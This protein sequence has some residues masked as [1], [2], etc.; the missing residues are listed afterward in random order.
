MSKKHIL[1]LGFLMML[2]FPATLSA[3][4]TLQ[5]NRTLLVNSLQT[6]PAGKVWKVE[7]VLTSA[8]LNINT[9]SSSHQVQTSA[10]VVNGSTI[11]VSS[12]WG[13]NQAIGSLNLT[14]LPIW[15]PAGTT[16]NVSTNVNSISVIEF[17]E[18][19]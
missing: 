2:A 4:N 10:I 16:L 18:V 1:F 9:G 15:L 3:Q 5:Y 17:N 13:N 6:V 14:K 7:S 11:Y 12:T 8:N 19:S